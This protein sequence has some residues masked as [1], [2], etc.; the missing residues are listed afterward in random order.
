MT[1]MNLC[2]ASKFSSR[3]VRSASLYASG[4]CGA[5]LM[6]LGPAAQAFSFEAGEGDQT[7]TAKVYGYARLNAVYDIN[8]D[9]GLT[10]QSGNFSGLD[11]TGD[12]AEGFFDADAQ[13]SRLGVEVTHQSGLLVKL[14]TD[15]RGGNLR[16]RHA[17][18]EYGSWMV[19]RNW[20]NFNSF[21]GFTST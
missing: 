14:E 21:V 9:I 7:V 2:P 5:L 3:S 8:E 16:L 6:G 1:Q 11:F 17:Y 15:F 10:T 18:G 13:Q 4:L 19:G 20:S 12:A